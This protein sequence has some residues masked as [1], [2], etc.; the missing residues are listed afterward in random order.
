M[1]DI[2][3]LQKKIIPEMTEI[4]EKRYNILRNIYYNEPIGRRTL[5]GNLGIGERIIRTEVNILKKQGLLEIKSVGM[6]VTE[7][8]KIIIDQLKGFIHKLKGLTNLEESLQ[9]KLKI[10]KIII[11]PGDFDKDNFIKKDVGKTAAEFIKNTIKD[12][13]IIGITGGS[14]MASVA[15]A[16]LYNTKL[17]DILVLPARGG[18][19]RNVEMQ[20]NNIAARLAKRLDGS[21]KLLHVPDNINKEALNTLLQVEEIRELVDMLKKMNALIFGIGRADTMAKRRK[22]SE[23]LLT[24]LLNKGAVAEAFGYY[25]DLNGEIVRES[26]TVGITLDDFKKIKT[27]I[28]V[29][30]GSEKA[31]AI[32]AISSLKKDIVLITDEGAAKEILNM[33]K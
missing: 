13:N 12:N 18:I 19:G 10:K 3:T 1:E 30:C 23:E 33:V 15:D 2:L 16:M 27:V 7:D 26:S 21:Y 5:A 11:V 4:L 31:K 17:K 20:A 29:A 14:T 22:L 8:G 24:D 9:Q 32:K 25:F 6:N 28:G